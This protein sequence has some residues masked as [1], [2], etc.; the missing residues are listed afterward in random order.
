MFAPEHKKTRLVSDRRE[1][2]IT[3]LFGYKNYFLYNTAL[4]ASDAG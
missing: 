2:V 1:K 3:N 4:A